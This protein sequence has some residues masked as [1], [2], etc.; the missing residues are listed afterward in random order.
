MVELSKAD[1]IKVQ[2]HEHHHRLEKRWGLYCML[3]SLPLWI[4]GFWLLTRP[5]PQDHLGKFYAVAGAGFATGWF[6]RHRRPS[7][8]ENG[9]A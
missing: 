3:C 7:T 6:A 5:S 4:G 2:E 8:T 9:P 1:A